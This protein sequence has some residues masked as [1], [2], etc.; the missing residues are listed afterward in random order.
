VTGEP[1]TAAAPP[2]EEPRRIVLEVLGLF[3][4]ATVLAAATFQVGRFVAPVGRHVAD[5]IAVIFYAVPVAR[6]WQR[7]RDLYDY[8]FNLKGWRRGALLV[9]A[10][11]LVVFPLFIV[12]FVLFYG[13]V[14]GPLRD[15]L[16]VLAPPNLCRRFAGLGSFHPAWPGGTAW[17]TVVAAFTQLVA[18]A[19]PEEFF[20]RGYLQG[21][22]GEALPARRRLLGVPVGRALLLAAVLFALGHFLIDF[23]ARRLAVFFPALVFGWLRDATGS[24]APGA[25]FHA[26]CN[27]FSD[28]LH[29]SFFG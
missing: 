11:T 13:A 19:L 27:L 15:T 4:I 1:A 23:D 25:A 26:L 5:I 28:G 12:A 29:R 17:G 8:G 2:A 6:L 20:F 9:A 14:C 24:I 21:R 10:T 16:G 7:R 18:V 22:L 3:A